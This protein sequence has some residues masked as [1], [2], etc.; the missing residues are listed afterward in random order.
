MFK[1]A[2]EECDG[3]VARAGFGG[4]PGGVWGVPFW[5]PQAPEAP[6]ASRRR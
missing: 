2:L 1:G 3:W 4:A 5:G 6:Q